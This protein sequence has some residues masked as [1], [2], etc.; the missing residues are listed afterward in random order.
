MPDEAQHI[1]V[2]H[3]AG[4]AQTTLAL[5][6]LRSLRQHLPQSR[7]TV[8]ASAVAADLIRLA[9]QNGSCA[10]EVLTVGRLRH[11][12]LLKPTAFYRSTKAISELRHT[13]FDL[14]IEF[15][16][17]TEG[18]LVLNLANPRKR[19]RP[20]KAANKGLSGI[21]EQF[22]QSGSTAPQAMTHLAHEYL[23]KLEPLG[24]RPVESEPHLTTDREADARLEKLLKKHGVEFGELLVGIHPGAGRI[25]HRWPVER[26]ISIGSRL[27][28]NFNARVLVFAGPQE[29]GLAKQ[30]VAQLP[31]KRAIAIQSPKL[32]DLVSAF[33][34]LSLLVA[35]H[36]GP[37]HVAAAA[38][39]PVAVISTFVKHSSTDVLAARCE[40][41]RA[42]HVAMNSEEAVYEAACR[43]LKTNRADSLRAR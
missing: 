10:D 16:K 24:V 8:A 30:I 14:A 40:H 4:L 39:A 6:A 12:E 7:I 5:P 20:T 35:N 17:N 9:S 13:N 15:N 32:P 28:H 43:L 22:T 26:F 11:A 37:A 3:I 42:S 29:R 34:R 38:G 19:L 31:A 21:L 23:K 25:Q 33:A 27:I 36:S 41:I 2:I 1:L 18:S